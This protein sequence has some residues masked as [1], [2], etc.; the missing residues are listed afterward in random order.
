MTA[1]APPS[2]SRKKSRIADLKKIADPRSEIADRGSDMEKIDRGSD[3]VD[4]A[5]GRSPKNAQ[6]A[7]IVENTTLYTYK[8]L[9]TLCNYDNRITVNEK[10]PCN[11]RD[12]LELDLIQ[13][14]E[15][16]YLE[17]LDSDK[18]WSY[19]IITADLGTESYQVD[20]V[21]K[22]HESR[23]YC[24]YNC[25]YQQNL[26]ASLEDLKL[27][28]DHH[29]EI[30]DP[31]DYEYSTERNGKHYVTLSEWYSHYLNDEPLFDDEATRDICLNGEEL[32]FYIESEPY[33]HCLTCQAG[34]SC[35]IVRFKGQ[36]ATTQCINCGNGHID[37]PQ[38]DLS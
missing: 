20:N 10:T 27:T 30:D 4:L 8:E 18:Q 19:E 32:A 3:I 29:V 35:T 23:M 34:T 22:E 5:A 17:S 28:K 1:P 13:T 15:A 7:P 37:M 9:E 26:I 36:Q 6:E 14:A 24:S 11:S 38:G 21:P 2:F 25:R 12:D 31:D 33:I 16:A